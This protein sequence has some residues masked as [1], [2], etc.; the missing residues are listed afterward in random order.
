MRTHYCLSLSLLYLWLK[1]KI[2]IYNLPNRVLLVEKQVER[3]LRLIMHRIILMKLIIGE[4]I[5]KVVS[6]Y[7]TKA[8]LD[9][10]VKVTFL[11]RL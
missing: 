9:D 1:Q 6:T 8:G 11:E 2:K 10:I 4:N 7:A 5:L 3:Y